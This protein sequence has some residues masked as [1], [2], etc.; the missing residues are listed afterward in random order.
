MGLID[1]L[2]TPH[3]YGRLVLSPSGSDADFDGRLCDC[4]FLFRHDG[5]FWMTYVGFDGV[6]YQ[7]GL[8]VS[9]DLV[10]WTKRGLLLGRGPKGSV[11]EYNAALTC[12]LR[13]N[14]LLGS[15]ELKKIDG[16]FIGTYH[17]YPNAGYESGPA[18]IGLC[19][20]DD[21]TH[22]DVGEP[23]L[24]AAGGGAWERGGLYKSWLLEHDGVYYMFYNAK[25]DKS[26]DWVEQTGLAT[27]TDLKNW[28]RH[29][30]NPVIVNGGA[31]EPD[32]L[33]AS[34]P[35]VFRHE[36]KW[37]MFY[38]ALA[39]DCHARD[40]AAVSDD[41]LNWTKCKEVLIDVG[42]PGS[43][44]SQHAHKPGIIASA[45]RLHHFYCAVSDANPPVRGITFAR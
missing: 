10:H 2:R 39:R 19:F 20:S 14:E 41:L 21:L 33:F 26:Y 44:D 40:L 27:S 1:K 18:A 30:G 38:F 32:E 29:A 16:R 3:K 43:I 31:G 4:P 15:G 25:T 45:G 17:A 9:D 11:T 8:A 6:G 28:T 42:P 12:I 23:V 35:C 37:V 24:H 36:G 5:R 13:D 22:W 7:T 34:D